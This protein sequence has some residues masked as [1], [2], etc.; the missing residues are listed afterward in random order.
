M[1][2]PFDQIL[3]KSNP[4]KLPDV[5]AVEA[6]FSFFLWPGMGKISEKHPTRTENLGMSMDALSARP[7]SA[8]VTLAQCAKSEEDTGLVWCGAGADPLQFM[9][10]SLT[11]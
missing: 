6:V 5:S 4:L 1:Q 3:S 11:H 9:V 7:D 10:F 2:V 8:L